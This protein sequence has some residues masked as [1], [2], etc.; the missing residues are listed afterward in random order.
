MVIKATSTGTVTYKD[1]KNTRDVVFEKVLDFFLR[2]E[3]F[4]G[5]CCIQNDD[6]QLEAPELLAELADDVFQFDP[7]WNEDS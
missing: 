6:P 5:E 1:D 2:L 4:N 3:C 7:V